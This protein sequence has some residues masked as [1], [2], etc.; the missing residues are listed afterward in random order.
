MDLKNI[1]QSKTIRGI[2]IGLAV[3]VILLIVFQAGQAIG[4]RKARF[5]GN[6]GNNFERNFLG[7][8]SGGIKMNFNG[9]IPGGHGAAGEIISIDLPQIIISGPDKLEKTILIG[10]STLIRRFQGDIKVSDL[11]QGEF[12]VVLGN[13]NDAGQIEA[14]LIRIMPAPLDGFTKQIPR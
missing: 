3:A 2:L 8:R 6:F 12:V 13:P 14:K 1:H 5:A 10:T 7:S 11:Q 4:Y 9:G